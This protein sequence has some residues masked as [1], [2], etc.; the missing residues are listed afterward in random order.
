MKK[1]FSLI[2]VL[3]LS[4]FLAACSE[5]EQTEEK[6]SSEEE[7]STEEETVEKLEIYTTIFPLEDFANKIGGDFVNV[8]NIVPV[9][10]DAHS[11]EPSARDL[12]EIAEGDALIYNGAGLEGFV[13]S[14]IQTLESEEI[15]IVKASD[16]IVS[17]NEENNQGHEEEEEH[18]EHGHDSHAQEDDE[19]DEHN[20][21]DEHSEEESEQ[22]DTHDHG[23]DVDPHVW[24]DPMLAITLAENIKDTLINLMPEQEEL[25]TAN[26]DDVKAEL[27]VINE[28]FEVM[29]DDTAKDTFLVSHAG[30]G[31]W[32]DRYGL[33]Q[34]G[35]AGMSPSN[36]PSQRQLKEIID[37]ADEYGLEYVMYEQNIPAKVAEIV[38]EEVGA[39]S[40]Y[41]HNLEAL[42]KED[43]ENNE[44]YFSLMRKNIEALAIALQ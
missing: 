15:E 10:G 25:F 20:E 29:I 38:K 4:L 13:D 12:I 16:G 35:I 1:I 5:A 31:Y 11:F 3:F 22:E 26:F 34:I 36:D 21:H 19:H 30:Y 2:I 37:L 9:G 17:L 33:K 43:I 39:E 40:L 18:D 23:H 41:L 14:I 28:E 8:T 44:D 42:V 7:T 27:E 6:T 24:L 32:E